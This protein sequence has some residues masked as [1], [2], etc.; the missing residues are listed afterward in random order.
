M[1]RWYSWL[2]IYRSGHV[3]VHECEWMS[4]E[5]VSVSRDN[6]AFCLSFNRKTIMYWVAATTTFDTRV[7]CCWDVLNFA[8]KKW[9]WILGDGG[10]W[11]AAFASAIATT[12]VHSPIAT[13]VCAKHWAAFPWISIGE[14]SL[15][16]WKKVFHENLCLQSCDWRTTVE[17]VRYHSLVHNGTCIPAAWSSRWKCRIGVER[18]LSIH[19]RRYRRRSRLFHID[20]WESIDWVGYNS[21]A[22]WWSSYWRTLPCRW[23]STAI[24]SSI[25]TVQLWNGLFGTRFVGLAMEWQQRTL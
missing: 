12:K 3:S 14:S 16:V 11:N 9:N 20:V 21:G 17:T 23:Q 7:A 1:R 5:N 13:S 2:P 19:D 6:R 25:D 4:N 24:R 8:R 22:R 15:F 18:R 10:S